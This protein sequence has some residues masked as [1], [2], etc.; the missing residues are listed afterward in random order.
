MSH[1]IELQEGALIISDAHYSTARP[2]LLSLIKDIHSKK[3]ITPQLIL[4]GDIFDALFIQVPKTQENNREMIELLNEISEEIEL[5]YLEGNHDFNLQNIFLN[6]KVISL[7]EQPII[8]SFQDKKVAL[9]HG[10]FDIGVSYQI[11]TAFIRNSLVLNVLNIINSLT[12]NFILTKLDSYLDEKDD[13][14]EFIGFETYTQGRRLD[15]F[16]CKYFIEGH[17]HQNKSFSF[18]KLNYINLAAFA[19]NQ[20]YFTVKSTKDNE[21]VIDENIYVEI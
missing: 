17:Y 14:K 10:D 20:R 2:K 13:C 5:I 1:N 21:L 11:Y 19:C 4:M 7:K 18:S 15:T 16:G 9:A 8:C 6:A 12:N 3:I